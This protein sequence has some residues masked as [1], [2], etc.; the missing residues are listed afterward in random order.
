MA[1]GSETFAWKLF[2]DIERTCWEC[3]RELKRRE[4][5]AE[6]RTLYP[7]N[8]TQFHCKECSDKNIQQRIQQNREQLGLERRH[9]E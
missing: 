3:G 5:V 7:K 1:K 4:D 9:D 2:P 8:I 6:H